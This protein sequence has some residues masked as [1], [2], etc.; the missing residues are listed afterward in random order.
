MYC[1]SMVQVKKKNQISWARVEIITTLVYLYV[2]T[3]KVS[4][5]HVYLGAVSIEDWIVK[6]NKPVRAHGVRPYIVLKGH[7][8]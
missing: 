8:I 7:F 6:Q 4:Y 1:T 5:I 2:H 3:N